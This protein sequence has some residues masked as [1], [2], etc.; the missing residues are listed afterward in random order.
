MEPVVISKILAML[1]LLLCSLVASFSPYKFA[2][3]LKRWDKRQRDKER[4]EHAARLKLVHVHPNGNAHHP[5]P[6]SPSIDSAEK[7]VGGA[8]DKQA[9]KS[10]PK[11]ERIMSMMICFSGG[12]LLAVAMIHMLPEV[13]AYW[14]WCG[15]S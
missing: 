13:S 14:Y 6:G 10:V 4:A 15:S 7:N 3:V 8:G 2:S 5:A 12:V 9:E 1:S 11:S